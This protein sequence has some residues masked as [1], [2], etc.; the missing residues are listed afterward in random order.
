VQL[1][2]FRITYSFLSIYLRNLAE[3]IESKSCLLCPNSAW[4]D[5]RVLGN[6]ELLEPTS[7]VGV[8]RVEQGVLI[9]ESYAT[10]RCHLVTICIPLLYSPLGY[11]F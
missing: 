7:Y 1:K 11:T 9:V 8:G 4:P 2:K 3:V 10:P 5:R 6:L